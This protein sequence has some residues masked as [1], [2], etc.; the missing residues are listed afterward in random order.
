[1]ERVLESDWLTLLELYRRTEHIKTNEKNS[2]EEITFPSIQSYAT[3]YLISTFIFLR[4][5][6]RAVGGDDY[7]TPFALEMSC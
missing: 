4:L 2:N 1:M 7:D 3:L 5:L 6:W